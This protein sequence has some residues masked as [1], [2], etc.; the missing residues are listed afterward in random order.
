MV[1][2]SDDRRRES[3]RPKSR[4]VAQG[5][6]RFSQKQNLIFVNIPKENVAPLSR[7]LEKVGLTPKAPLGANRL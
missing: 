5:Q 1:R 2:R 3:C 4:G 6:V 7:E